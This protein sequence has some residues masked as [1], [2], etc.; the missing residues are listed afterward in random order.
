MSKL[1]APRDAGEPGCVEAGPA[2]CGDEATGGGRGCTGSRHNGRN[3]I[4][5][6]KPTTIKPAKPSNAGIRM[7]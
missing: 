3:P 1:G 4:K 6:K 5:K 7:E 2:V